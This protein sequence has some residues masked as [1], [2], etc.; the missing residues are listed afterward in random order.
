MESS[1]VVIIGTGLVGMSYAYSLVN[2]GVVEEL[3]LIDI[4]KEKAL[5]EAMDLNHGLSFSPR[6]MKITAGDYLDCQDA[7]L[8]VIT[9][10]VNQKDKESRLDLLRRN[11]LI[12]KQVV[13]Q[14]VSSGFDG[15]LLVASNPVDIL[16]YVA[17]KESGLP[18][19]RVIGSGTSLDT[20][21]LRYEISAKI[22][23]SVDN[24]HAYIFGEHGDSEFVVWSKAFIGA[25]PMLDVIE[26]M[27]QI[28]FDD[29]EK[30]YQRVKNAAYEIIKRKG[31][32]YYGIGMAL[33]KITKAIL[34]NEN[35]IMPIS[36]LNEGAYDIENVYI[37]LTA[38]LNREGVDHI[39]KL[40]LNEEETKKLQ[41][42]A[43]ILNNHLQQLYK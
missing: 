41:S 27:N 24:V 37:G 33:V 14:V 7:N 10:G 13:N 36:V 2:Q 21:R 38:M 28:E 5:G 34:N 6:K 31:A 9:A 4:N 16:S 11:A 1:K 15:I 39:V 32:T 29:L 42:S 22:N 3:V 40:K 43:S 23:V 18:S 12:M 35:R 30:I 20:S 26:D 8:V 17:W 19:S 25:K